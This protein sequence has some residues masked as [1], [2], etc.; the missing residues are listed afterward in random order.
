MKSIVYKTLIAP[1]LFIAGIACHAQDI[2]V[3]KLDSIVL[4]TMLN[5]YDFNIKIANIQ[6]NSNEFK[7]LGKR[8]CVIDFYADW[9]RPCRI[10]TPIFNELTQEY[11]GIVDF[12][13]INVDDERNL[14]T[15]FGIRS[16]PTLLLIPMSGKP[17][18]M[19]GASPKA[20]LKKIIEDLLLKKEKE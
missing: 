11:A 20:E 3:E 5:E 14:A 12:Y 17:T 9:C 10:L 18:L 7:Y 8:P 16:I 19:Q 4:P 2:R 1:L 13:K 15:A 6:N